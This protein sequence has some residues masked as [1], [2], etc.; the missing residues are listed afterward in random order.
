MRAARGHEAMY[1]TVLLAFGILDWPE[2][3]DCDL[4]EDEL[5]SAL[6]ASLLDRV[7]SD[8]IAQSM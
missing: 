6:G 8:V 3:G 1:L 2:C 7:A 5:A 4:I